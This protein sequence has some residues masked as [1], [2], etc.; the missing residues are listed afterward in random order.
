VPTLH[1]LTERGA[2]ANV[3]EGWKWPLLVLAV[4]NAHYELAGRLLE[5]GADPNAGAQGWTALIARRASRV[6]LTDEFARRRFGPAER[7]C[8]W[9]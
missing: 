2:D 7:I 1:A 9:E 8:C 5:R 6:A 4:T 3:H